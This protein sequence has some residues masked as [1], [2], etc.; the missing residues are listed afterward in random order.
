MEKWKFM[1]AQKKK[2]TGRDT[3]RL[4]VGKPHACGAQNTENAA[5]DG[6]G[7]ANRR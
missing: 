3:E 7:R 1:H 4:K 5:V 2:V 6:E